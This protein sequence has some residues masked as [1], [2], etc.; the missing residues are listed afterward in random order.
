MKRFFICILFAVF[1]LLITNAQGYC[2]KHPVKT[3]AVITDSAHRNGTTYIICGGASDIMA[4][5]IINRINMTGRMK[6]PLLGETMSKI[7]QRNL[8]LYYGTFFNE[9]KYN[10]NIDFV[11]LKRVT[12]NVYADY[13]LLITSGIDTQSQFLKETWWNKWGISVSEPIV[14]TYRLVTMVTL[15]DKKTYRIVWQDLY[16]RDI[17]AENCDLALTKFSPSYAQL[18]KIKKYSKTMS[19][20]VANN[21]DK[22]V[23]PWILPPKEPKAVE[24]K[25]RFVNEGTKV[26]YPT[27]NGD[28]VKENIDEFTT[29]TKKKWNNYQR[30]RMQKKHIENVR[31]LE[32]RQQEEK[33]KQQ[34]LQLKEQQK[35]QQNESVQ[36]T[37]QNKKQQ[38]ERLFDS[39]RDDIEGISNTLPPQ[40]ETAEINEIKPAVQIQDKNATEKNIKPVA[41]QKQ[42]N[43]KIITPVMK[44]PNVKTPA[45]VQKSQPKTQTNTKTIQNTQKPNAKTETNKTQQEPSQNELKENIKD[46]TYPNEVPYYD[47][48]LKN[49]YLKKIGS[50]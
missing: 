37:K 14:P 2:A 34:K 45:T 44:K 40:K 47:W 31:R 11:N 7:T 12:K 27:V 32:K 5:D 16:Q 21:V 10:Y 8:P 6:A 18:A 46:N 4:T 38:N 48:N 35:I 41:E 20:Y 43:D 36:K 29:E 22:I 28:V 19:E 17:K 9:Y 23:N 3:V 26:Y 15:I 49:I 39:I 30:Q 24:M 13:L 25:S 50:V 1:A 33:I 42:T